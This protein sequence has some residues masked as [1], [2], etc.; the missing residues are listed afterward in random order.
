MQARQTGQPSVVGELVAQR[1]ELEADHQDFLR[2]LARGDYL[3]TGKAH[4]R[5]ASQ[6]EGPNGMTSYG[7]G[8]MRRE[9]NKERNGLGTLE[10]K[11]DYN[12]NMDKFLKMIKKD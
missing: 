2:N 8:G 4:G 6:L 5:Y 3:K 7:Y 9:R 11:D 10:N 1:R 12:S